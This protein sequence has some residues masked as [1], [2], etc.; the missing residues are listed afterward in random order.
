MNM[1][2][3]TWSEKF[4]LADLSQGIQRQF[5]GP[6]DS[7]AEIYY[8]AGPLDQS[9]S[10]GA[11]EANNSKPVTQRSE[12]KLPDPLSI[13]ASQ[14]P[15]ASPQSAEGFLEGPVEQLSD[16]GVSP[17]AIVSCIV[18]TKLKKTPSDIPLEKTINDVTGG[19]CQKK[20]KILLK[21]LGFLTVL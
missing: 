19:K 14:P 2:K 6:A 17:S 3:R 1:M 16:I 7:Q 9:R 20:G 12:P 4:A 5:L 18:A 11:T 15:E 8:R 10:P 13:S 21:S